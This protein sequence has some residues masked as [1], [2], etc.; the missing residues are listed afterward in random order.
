M[1][2]KIPSN[3]IVKSIYQHT[4]NLLKPNYFQQVQEKIMDYIKENEKN[5]DYLEIEAKFGIFCFQGS[6]V[7]ELSKIEETFLIPET[8]QKQGD[9]YYEFKAGLRPDNFYLIWNAVEKE[10]KLNGSNIDLL[11]TFISKDIVY[12]TNK[13]KSIMFHEGRVINEETIRKEDK[14]QINV[15]N[16]GNDFR[17]TCCKE[18]PTEVIESDKEDSVREKFRVSY[19]LS[20]F[21]VDFTISKDSKNNYA[22]EIE[23]ELNQLKTELKKKPINYKTIFLILDRFIQNVHN[24]YSVLIPRATYENYLANE[25]NGYDIGENKHFRPEEIGNIWGNYFK[26]NLI[27]K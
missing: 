25:R 21:R 26:N 6:G 3:I 13:R 16:F 7:K 12:N 1:E 18:M 22:Y 11:G 15:R 2:M 5:C 14:R 20:F 24:L 4:F 9:S 23:I 19:Q 8:I 10:S 17:I 27:H